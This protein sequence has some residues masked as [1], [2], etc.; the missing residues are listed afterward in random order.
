M[1]L[2]NVSLTLRIRHHHHSFVIGNITW[3][4]DEE[5]LINGN[6]IADVKFEM[7]QRMDKAIP[8]HRLDLQVDL[9]C[10][11]MLLKSVSSD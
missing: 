10:W 1:I 7:D 8:M 5:I 6:I 3:K 2:L 9:Q 11:S 4:F